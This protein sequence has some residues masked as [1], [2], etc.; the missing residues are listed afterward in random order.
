MTILWQSGRS[1]SLSGVAQDPKCASSRWL[2]PARF[3]TD[4]RSFTRIS[5]GC[6]R[7]NTNLRVWQRSCRQISSS[8]LI[9]RHEQHDGYSHR[10]IHEEEEEAEDRCGTTEILSAARRVT[11][12]FTSSFLQALCHMNNGE[13]V[14]S[15]QQVK[16]IMR[17]AA[18]LDS[19][20]LDQ[21]FLLYFELVENEKGWVSYCRLRNLWLS[22]EEADWFVAQGINNW[23]KFGE[24]WRSM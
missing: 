9:H 21:Y 16:L 13:R 12:N 5:S 6:H 7:W 23:W 11:K 17:A 4:Y 19:Q 10:P 14:I 18:S 15:C 22:T 1:V 24:N 20:P 8:R 3:D 2:V